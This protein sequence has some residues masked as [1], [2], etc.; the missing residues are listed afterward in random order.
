MQD[1]WLAPT[2]AADVTDYLSGE[3][4]CQNPDNGFVTDDQ[5]AECQAGLKEFIPVA[6]NI[7]FAADIDGSEACNYYFDFDTIFIL[8]QQI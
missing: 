5:I 2:T 1:L 3:S 8:I 7:L 6:L 4:F